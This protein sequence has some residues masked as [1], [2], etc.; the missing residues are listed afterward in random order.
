MGVSSAGGAAPKPVQ[1]AVN[2]DQTAQSRSQVKET[3]KGL[4]DVMSDIKDLSELKNQQNFKTTNKESNS[5]L[6]TQSN[7]VLDQLKQ[8][9]EAQQKQVQS[10]SQSQQTQ[11]GNQKDAQVVAEAMAGL[12]MEE[13]LGETDELQNHLK[14]KWIF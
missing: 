9:A 4:S 2:I 14:K 5:K 3:A 13:E 11:M 1:G 10:Q 7:K 12:M 6:D 8:Q